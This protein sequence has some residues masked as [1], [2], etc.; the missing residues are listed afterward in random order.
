MRQYKVTRRQTTSR[1]VPDEDTYPVK[2][3]KPLPTTDDPGG[4]HAKGYSADCSPETPVKAD[5]PVPLAPAHSPTAEV[6][7]HER[8]DEVRPTGRNDKGSYTPNDRLMG[9]D[10]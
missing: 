8:D 5:D 1:I 3:D 9:S 4:A 6:H 7:Q 2:A 10:R